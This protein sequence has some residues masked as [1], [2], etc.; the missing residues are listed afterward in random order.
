MYG[1]SKVLMHA[2]NEAA[3]DEEAGGKLIELDG[4]DDDVDD[5]VDDNSDTGGNGDL[6]ENL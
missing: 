5:D 2:N 3:G 4:D 6:A 1:V